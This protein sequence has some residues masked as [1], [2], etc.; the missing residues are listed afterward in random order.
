VRVVD[1]LAEHV[2]GPLSP[3]AH[4]L[5]DPEGVDDPVAVAAGCDAQDLHDGRVYPRPRKAERR[6]RNAFC[7]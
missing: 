6:R 5:G 1:Q 7:P 3:L 2:D 4:A